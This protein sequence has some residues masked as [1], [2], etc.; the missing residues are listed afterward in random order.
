MGLTRFTPGR[1]LDKFFKSSNT[2]YYYSSK[3]EYYKSLFREESS[4]G[5]INLFW[6]SDTTPRVDHIRIKFRDI[7]FNT[8]Y[9][10]V[11]QKLGK[12]RF[13]FDNTRRI[14][15]H[16]VIFY[17]FNIGGYKVISQLHFLKDMFFYG[18]YT[19]K[20]VNTPSLKKIEH[21]LNVKYFSL[22]DAHPND[23]SVIDAEGNCLI[24]KR[25]MYLTIK[26]IS[27]NEVFANSIQ[28]QFQAKQETR[29]IKEQRRYQILQTQL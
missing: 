19:F 9:A 24:I 27:G 17:K 3:E 22:A 6:H 8:P 21:I 5:L 12:P 28:N 20:D 4:K 29:Q 1:L 7:E 11:V 10:E 23:N 2:Y 25:G 14:A 13:V 26:Y 16:K 15:N 18:S